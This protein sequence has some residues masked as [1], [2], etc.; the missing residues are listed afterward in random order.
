MIN[1]INYCLYCKE[2]NE[3]DTKLKWFNHTHIYGKK[4]RKKHTPCYNLD[5]WF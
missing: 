5:E 3:Q 2:K 1:H 4:K